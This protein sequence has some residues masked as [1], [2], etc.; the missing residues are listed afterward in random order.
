MLTRR[1][2]RSSG[3]GIG[4]TGQNGMNGMDHAISADTT[5][6]RTDWIL[7]AAV[8]LACLL[9]FTGKAVHIDDPLYIWAAKQIQAHPLDPYGVAV[10]WYG[11]TKSL[12]AVTKN[13]PLAS[14]VMAL[15]ASLFGWGEPVLHLTV[16]LAALLV[17]LGTYRLASGICAYPVEAA[18]VALFT[19]V[20]MISSTTIMGDVLM[21][22]FWVWAAA[23]WMRGIREQHNGWLL[24]GAL[25]VACSALTKYFGAALIPLLLAWTAAERKRAERAMLY[26]LLP[27]LLLGLYQWWSGSLYGRG[28]L[29]DAAAYA[30]GFGA[31]GKGSYGRNLLAGLSFLGGC[32]ITVAFHA[33]RLWSRP[34]I[35]II[36]SMALV[37]LGVT[38]FALGP[39]AP[40]GDGGL[41][42]NVIAQGALFAAGG[43]GLLALAVGEW[44]RRRDPW[45][46]LLLLW[47]AGTLLFAALVNWTVNGRSLLPIAPAVGLLVARR[48]DARAPA[49]G[50]GWRTR[51]LLPAALLSLLVA[52]ADLR[53]A[54]GVR[55][56]VDLIASHPRAERSR[57]WFQG[58]W[59]FQYYMEARGGKA[60]DVAGSE[61][62]P[63]DILIVPM[64]NT[65]LFRLPAEYVPLRDSLSSA[66][67]SW[68]ATMNLDA[69]AGFYA[70][71]WGPLP[72]VVGAIPPERY[73]VYM[74]REPVAFH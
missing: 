33:H 5:T 47:I 23:F 25:L 19:P 14:Y 61:L 3:P 38:L 8:T 56:D 26:L 20:V 51:V 31:I 64:N 67:L 12:A 35:L 22:A 21:L 68:L 63:G 65:S 52:Y 15:A 2:H 66:H 6:R 30:T 62:L 50:R 58:H 41:G 39:F 32:F 40:G 24:L 49:S 36:G 4:S 13:P 7:L 71:V 17:V 11:T 43:F 28:L 73:L 53:L 46:L 37:A 69:G 48:L 74:V 54:D 60:L 44:I 9:P 34:G 72:F 59:G 42:W 55:A 1:R 45:S 29:A 18:L 16:I 27:A 57:L 70:H 10:N